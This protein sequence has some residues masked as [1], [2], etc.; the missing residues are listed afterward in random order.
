VCVC[1]CVCVCVEGRKDILFVEKT[2]MIAEG[3]VLASRC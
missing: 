2:K 3:R 1:V